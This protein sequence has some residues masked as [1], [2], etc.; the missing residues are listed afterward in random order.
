[1]TP[2][3]TP[4]QATRPRLRT[5][6]GLAVALPL[7]LLLAA[8][9]W[10][11]AQAAWP[12]PTLRLCVLLLG[13]L[14]VAGGAA[15]LGPR[16][17]RPVQRELSERAA[18]DLSPL[19]AAPVQELQSLVQGMNDLL[20]QQR[21]ALDEQKRFLADATHQLRTPLAVLRTQLQ[22]AGA[23]G[24]AAL[25]PL[26]PEMLRVVDRA[27]GV[28][29]EL[30]ARMKVEQRERQRT[31][32]QPLRLDELAREAALEFSPLM[33]DKRLDFTL[34]AAALAVPAD[35]WMLGELVRNLLANAIQHSAHG[36]ALGIVVRQAAGCGELIVWDSGA[37]ISEAQRERL[38]E[39]FAAA[40]RGTGV[41]LGL[42]IC[43]QIGQALGADVQLF[44]RIDGN[45]GVGVDAVVRWPQATLGNPAAARSPSPRIF[46]DIE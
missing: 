44:N 27:A 3:Q 4:V 21:Q 22:S 12:G 11:L 26:V 8:D 43:R 32:W 9:A 38:F 31:D 36:A 34:D 16:A 10:L 20:A 45:R 29:N 28:T 37:G 41:G 2:D 46:G 25:S 30:L 14:L 39:P 40:T 5:R 13:A 18:G 1:M 15:W 7:L 24:G 33:A 23:G 6:L 19:S 42:S 35:A 17:L